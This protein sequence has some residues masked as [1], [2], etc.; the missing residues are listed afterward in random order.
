MYDECGNCLIAIIMV[1]EI[2]VKL[3]FLKGFN[4]CIEC[5]FFLSF[6]QRERE[7]ERERLLRFNTIELV[8]VLI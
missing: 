2:Q 3:D 8:P 6:S 1:V 7:R 5:M 4:T